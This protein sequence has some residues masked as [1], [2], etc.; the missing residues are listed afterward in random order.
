KWYKG[1]AASLWFTTVSTPNIVSAFTLNSCISHVVYAA[2]AVR[3]GVIYL[4]AMYKGCPATNKSEISASVVVRVVASCAFGIAN[5][6]VMS[7]QPSPASVTVPSKLFV[8]C[9]DS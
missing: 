6:A 1:K 8:A 3:G 7:V 9:T 5:L 4:N 2:D